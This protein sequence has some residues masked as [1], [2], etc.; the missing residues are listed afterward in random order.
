MFTSFKV[1]LWSA[2]SSTKGLAGQNN[3]AE[4]GEAIFWSCDVIND[5]THYVYPC[6]RFSTVNTL[7]DYNP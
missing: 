6:H 7:E 3:V 5:V 4:S 1:L 2:F